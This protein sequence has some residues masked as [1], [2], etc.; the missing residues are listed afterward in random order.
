MFF[1]LVTALAAVACQ[2]RDLDYDFRDTA[3]ITVIY[4]WDESGLNTKAQY[5]T[6]NPGDIINGRT[7]AFYPTDGS[8]PIIK[9]SHSDTITVN[10]LVGQYE[11]AFFNETFDD[12][13]NIRFEGTRQFASLEALAKD[14]MVATTRAGNTI[15]RQ[16]DILAVETMVPFEVTEDM[17]RYT[18]ILGT[19]KSKGLKS[20]GMKSDGPTTDAEWQQVQES[21]TVETRP[22]SVVYRG[23]VEVFVDNIDDIVTAGGYLSGFAGGYDYSAGAANGTAVS[24]KITLADFEFNEGSEKDGVMRSDFRCFGFR[25]GISTGLSGYTFD[26]RAVLVNG[27]VY[28]EQRVIDDLITEL[29][30]DGRITIHITI[31]NHHGSGQGGWDGE[32]DGDGPIQV[33]NVE[34][35]GGEGMWQVNVGD[36]DE[37]VVPI[38]M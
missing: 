13:D 35:V 3:E 10:L 28:Q 6:V 32:D 4:N 17:L 16:P 23:T 11:V 5:S 25:D 9:M 1:V 34:P 22:R 27:E 33:P 19:L 29:E 37:V 15:A 38:N 12:F 26:F 36:W 14:D 18:R 21:L 8:E 31:G 20:K 24:H 30:E 2:W 7:A